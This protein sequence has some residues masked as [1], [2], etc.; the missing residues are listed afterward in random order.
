MC[1]VSLTDYQVRDL[2]DDIN[3]LMGQKYHWEKR[4]Q[5]LGGADYTVIITHTDE[6]KARKKK[7]Y[8]ICIVAICT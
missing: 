8:F 3:K 4:I 6:R 7:T 2:N 5:E 1:I